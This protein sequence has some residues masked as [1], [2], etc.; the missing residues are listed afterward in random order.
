MGE[1]LDIERVFQAVQEDLY[2]AGAEAGGNFVKPAI[3]RAESH[4]LI[5]QQETFAPILYVIRVKDLEDA[6]QKHNGA[7]QGLSSAIFTAQLAPRRG[8]PRD[9]PAEP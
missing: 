7:S 2:R 8:L 5:V 6:I 9:R 3:V 4:Y 1:L